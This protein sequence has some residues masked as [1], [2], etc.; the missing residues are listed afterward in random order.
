MNSRH[1]HVAGKLVGKANLSELSFTT[2]QCTPKNHAATCYKLTSYGTLIG[3]DPSEI[4]SEVLIY[5]FYT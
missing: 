3:T 1:K 4:I 2:L 5:L